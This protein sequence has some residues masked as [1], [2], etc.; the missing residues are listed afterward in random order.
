M[1]VSSLHLFEIAVKRCAEAVPIVTARKLSVQIPT[2]YAGKRVDQTLAA[3]FPDFS[4]SRLQQWVREGYIRLGS[5]LPRSSDKVKGGE[6]IEIELPEIQQPSW[7]AEAIPLHIAYEDDHVLVINKPAGM[8]MHPGPGNRDHTLLNAALHHSPGLQSV[9]RAGIVH[10]LDKDTSGLLVVAKTESIRL[11][12]I[13]YLQKRHLKREYL[14]LAQGV[15]IAGGDIE[16]PIGR[17]PRQRTRMAVNVRGKPAISHY[18]LKAKYR[19]HTLVQVDLESGRTH[20]VR[21]HLAH[22]GYPVVG[23]PVYGGRLRIP[24]AAGERLTQALRGFRRQAL[25][26]VK[27]GLV[28]PVSGEAMEWTAPVPQDMQALI[29]ALEDDAKEHSSK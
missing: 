8:V 17:H 26:A 7:E 23:D 9:A 11:R 3:L 1:D 13:G 28:H 18:R 20:Q 21:V 25:H 12:L 22:I 19:A 27:L 14:A 29:N 24:P 4:R 10:R 16:A 6:A 15:M 5:K 2:E